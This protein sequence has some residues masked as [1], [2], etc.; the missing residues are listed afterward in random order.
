HPQVQPHASHSRP[1][2]RNALGLI[3]RCTTL[4]RAKERPA[5]LTPATQ[6]PKR[7]LARPEPS[8]AHRRSMPRS[9]TSWQG[10]RNEMHGKINGQGKRGARE[11]EYTVMYFS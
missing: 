11:N 3:L 9:M 1:P 10:Y 2:A 5:W 7:A 8:R 6:P 4:P